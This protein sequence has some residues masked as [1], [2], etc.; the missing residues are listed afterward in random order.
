MKNALYLLNIFR[1]FY[2]N[3]YYNTDKGIKNVD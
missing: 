1:I 3:T 2:Y